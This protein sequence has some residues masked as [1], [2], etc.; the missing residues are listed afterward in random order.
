MRG[1]AAFRDVKT[2]PLT[3]GIAYVYV[4]EVGRAA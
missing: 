3:G 4:G 1:T 2:R